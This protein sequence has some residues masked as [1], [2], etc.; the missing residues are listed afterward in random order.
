VPTFLHTGER[1]A[2]V[3]TVTMSNGNPML[4]WS[5]TF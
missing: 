4:M 5:G 1:P 2:A 3:P